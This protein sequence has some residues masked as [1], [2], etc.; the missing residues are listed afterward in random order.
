MDRTRPV[1]PERQSDYSHYLVM[2]GRL[3]GTWRR[4]LNRD[5]VLVAVASFKPL[6]STERAKVEAA[7]ERLAKFLECGVTV[8]YRRRG[9]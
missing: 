2:E 7:A 8:S 3:V 4:A 1:V 5:S 9:P 6:A